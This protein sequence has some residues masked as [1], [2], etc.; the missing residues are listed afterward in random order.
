LLLTVV[1]VLLTASSE[2]IL[3][4]LLSHSTLS[5]HTDISFFLWNGSS[6]AI[7]RQSLVNIFMTAL[8]SLLAGPVHFFYRRHYRLLFFIL[9]CI[10]SSSVSQLLA[11]LV[12]GGGMGISG[13]RLVFD[14]VYT[15]LVRFPLF[16]IFRKKLFY[17][18]LHV[19]KPL[20][21]VTK[22]RAIQDLSTTFVRVVA[23]QILGFRG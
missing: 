19:R 5:E 1:N 3:R 2:L 11:D 21:Q 10:F 23:L 13:K 8:A 7:H 6:W 17:S 4:Q 20:L 16:E 9:F 22:W 18:F 12:R 14:L 15:S